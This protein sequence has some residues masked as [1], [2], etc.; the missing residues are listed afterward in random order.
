M[1]HTDSSPWTATVHCLLRYLDRCGFDAAPKV[2]GNGFDVEGRETISYV[3]GRFIDRGVCS[4][5]AAYEIGA[6]VG[7][8]H[9]S[10]RSFEP[11]EE[12]I[13]RPW[14]GRTLGNRR[15]V[16]GHCDV[17]PW[18]VVMTNELPVAGIDWD[19][20]GPVDPLIDP[21]QAAG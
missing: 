17:A 6:M 16:I 9:A 7:R 4:E 19:Y 5:E 11:P 14:F 10:T 12:P 2:I 15:R 1:V 20:A 18:N 3:D 8:L 21:A 13:W